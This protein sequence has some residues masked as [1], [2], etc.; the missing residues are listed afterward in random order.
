MFWDDR[1]LIIISDVPTAYSAEVINRFVTEL[2]VRLF[3]DG[4]ELSFFEA[5]RYAY[6]LDGGICQISANTI[7][8]ESIEVTQASTLGESAVVSIDGK[9]YIFKLQDDA[10]AGIKG[11]K[12]AGVLNG[13]QVQMTA[14]EKPEHNTFIYVESLVDSTGFATYPER[15]TVDGVIDE[16]VENR[17]AVNGEGW[18]QFDFGSVKNL[19]SMA[20]AGVTQTERA[21][22]FDVLVSTDGV[23]WTTVHTG[24]APTTKE[25]MSILPLGDVQARYV[26]MIGR[27]NQLNTWNT[28]AEVRFYE[29]LA[30]Q[31]EDVSYWPAYFVDTNIIGKAGEIKKLILKGVDGAG[32]LFD[33]SDAAIVKY[34]VQNKAIATVNVDGSIT[35]LNP[36]STSLSVTATQDGYTKHTSVKITCE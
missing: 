20:F 36:G 16:L 19:H 12:D 17:W 35:F 32:D 24:G 26:K 4:K 22:K 5:D 23:S 31:Q 14:M 9:N 18:L 8:G 15:G 21:Y 29:S 30:Q 11:S 1:G 27:G 25:K 13:L 7:G 28:W 6:A 33:L 10:F 34:E 3:A 2:N